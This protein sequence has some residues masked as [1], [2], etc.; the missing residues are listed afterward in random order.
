MKRFFAVITALFVITFSGCMELFDKNDSSASYTVECYRQNA[1]NSGYALQPEET[2]IQGGI[3]GRM[4]GVIA[5]PLTGFTAK[6]VSQ[7]KIRSDGSTVVKL[8]Y[9]RKTV[10]LTFNSDGGSSVLPVSGKYGAAVPTVPAPAKSGYTFDGWTPVI[11]TEFPAVDTA[12]TAQWAAG[13]GIMYKVEH[14]QES[15]AGGRYT[16]T[17]SES[18]TGTTGTN[19]GYTPKTYAGFT[20]N[21]AKTNINGTVQAAGAI[22]ADGSTVVKLYY[23]RKTVTLT[24]N[25]D[26]GSS[27][28]PISGKY[29]A[30]VPTVSEPAKSGY[31]FGGWMPAIP[32]E[33]PAADT[34]YTAQWAAESGTM[35]KIEHYQE[36]AAGGRY[37][38]TDSESKTGTTGTNAAFT[39]K[40]YAGFT[41]NTAKTNI[42][43]TVQAAGAINADGSTIVKLY[44]DRKIVTLTF[45]SDGGSSV[46]S[47]SGKYGAAVPT[48]PEPAKSGYTFGGWMPVIPSEF[49]ADNATYTAKWKTAAY[50]ITGLIYSP[51][52]GGYDNRYAVTPPAY[53]S[54]IESVWFNGELGNKKGHKSAIGAAG[55][56]KDLKAYCID[57]FLYFH[58]E[59]EEGTIVELKDADGNVLGSF[60]YVS[61]GVDFTQNN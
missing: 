5:K 7:K 18:K 13:S 1:D 25:S 58:K 16:I 31:T 22:N 33:F 19:A 46:A 3:A 9:D 61:Q 47:I 49:P 23:D 29:G 37:T 54:R 12:Y 17:D 52:F 41:Q 40:T 43:G 36:S 28:L 56:N 20:Q 8:Y 55:Q 10:T 60:T 42:N 26:G 39:P 59:L 21:T 38:I 35:Y 11:P 45:N 30:A 32:H 2:S 27:V 57:G 51:A 44:Y 24:F 53:L 14:Y 15:A 50:K 48:V 34:A 4:T 6:A